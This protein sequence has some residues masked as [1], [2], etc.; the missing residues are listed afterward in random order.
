LEL[1]K[2]WMRSLCSLVN[3]QADKQNGLLRGQNLL[4]K[5]LVA[6]AMHTHDKTVQQLLFERGGD[7]LLTVKGNQSTL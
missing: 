4:G 6:D 3:M 7:Y 2:I 5:I 1:A